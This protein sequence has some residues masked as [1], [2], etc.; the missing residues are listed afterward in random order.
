VNRR[1]P[2]ERGRLVRQAR[3]I[4]A[5][6]QDSRTP[7]RHPAPDD[8][9]HAPARNEGVELYLPTLSKSAQNAGQLIEPRADLDSEPRRET[10]TDS[11]V[12]P[13]RQA[14]APTVAQPRSPIS[15]HK[16]GTEE[17]LLRLGDLSNI[18]DLLLGCSILSRCL[19]PIRSS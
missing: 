16:S 8:N 18:E 10:P 17:A 2:V 6:L 5:H 11:I 14:H 15:R 12:D 9:R 19:T 7:I 4:G 3:A 1:P 13:W